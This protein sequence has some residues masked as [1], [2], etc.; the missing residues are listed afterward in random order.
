MISHK[1][2][3]IFTHINKCA[4]TT[5]NNALLRSLLVRGDSQGYHTLSN[6]TKTGHIR[7]LNSMEKCK[8]SQDYFKFT[9]IRNPWD[10]MVSFYHYHDSRNWD[11]DWPWSVY[12]A[13]FKQDRPEF[14]EFIKQIYDESFDWKRVFKGRPGASTYNQKVPLRVSNSFM[15]LVDENDKLLTDFIGKY[16]NLQEDFNFICDKIGIPQQP[17]L[18]LRKSKHKPYWDYYNDETKE[19]VAE[20]YAKDIEHFNYTFI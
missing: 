7:L 10:K 3:F 16:E 8:R 6:P 12:G 11:L 20:K 17:L 14:N 19:I 15:W 2:K 1:Y 9:F 13:G 5:I 18:H 4:G